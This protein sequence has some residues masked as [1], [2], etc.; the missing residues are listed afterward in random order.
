M[1][2]FLRPDSTITQTTWTAGGHAEIND[3]SANDATRAFSQSLGNNGTAQLE[4][5]LSNPTGT[6][7]GDTATFR[8]RIAKGTVSGSTLTLDGGGRTVTVTPSVY[9]GGTLVAAGSAETATGTWTTFSFTPDMSSV[10]D[11]TD[12]RM[13]FDILVTGGGAAGNNRAGAISWAELEVPDALRRVTVI[14]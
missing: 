2:Q 3:A 8:F 13:R 5:G 11:W 6:P 1:S 9:Q 12:A 7:G 10:T 14:S 4:V